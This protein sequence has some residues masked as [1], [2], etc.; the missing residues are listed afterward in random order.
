MHDWVEAKC[1]EIL[2][3][4]RDALAEDSSILIDE[5]VLPDCGA[6]WNQARADFQMERSEQQWRDLLRKAG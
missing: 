2:Q 3:H 1:V 5:M 4:L 6:S